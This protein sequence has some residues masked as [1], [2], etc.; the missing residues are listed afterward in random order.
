MPP[1]RI[2]HK[3]NINHQQHERYQLSIPKPIAAPV[4]TQKPVAAPQKV[5]NMNNYLQHQ[6][7]VPIFNDRD[8]DSDQNLQEY[9][10]HDEIQRQLSNYNHILDNINIFSTLEEI[11]SKT[12]TNALIIQNQDAY[13]RI[14][15]KTTLQQILEEFHDF[16][17]IGLCNSSSKNDFYNAIEN[18]PSVIAKQHVTRDCFLL[19]SQGIQKYL[20]NVDFND[21]KKGEYNRPLFLYKNEITSILWKSFYRVTHLFDKIYCIHL[22]L[23]VNKKTHM[24]KY[25]YLLNSTESEFFYD[26]ILGYNL[27]SMKCLVD[28]NYYTKAALSQNLKKGALGCNITQKNIINDAVHNEY[29]YVLMLEDDVYFSKKYFLVLDVFFHKHKNID[30]LYLGISNN[31]DNFYKFFEKIDTIYDYSIL[32][33]KK[34][35]NQKICIGGFFAVVLS[36]KALKVFQER[37]NPID[38]ISD[39]LLCD[40]MFDIKKDF[41]DTERTKTN[42]QL[43]SLVIHK[44]LFIVDDSKPSLTESND[45]SMIQYLLLNPTISYLAKIK[46][47][48]FKIFHHYPLQIFISNTIQQWYTKLIDIFTG[49]FESYEVSSNISEETD[50]VLYSPFDNLNINNTQ[51]LYVVIH[52]EKTEFKSLCDICINT[53]KKK[54]HPFSIY[55]PQLFSSLW[56]R[57]QAYKT[58]PIRDKTKF[59][60]YMYSYDMKY[61]VDLFNF[62]S[63]YK[64]VDALGKSCSQRTETDRFVYNKDITYNDIAVEKY[65][66]YK[67]VLA[68]ENGLADGYITEKLINPIIAGSIPIYIGPKD[69]FDIINKKRVIYVYDFPSLTSLVEYIKTVDTDPVLYQ[70]IV[71]ENIFTGTLTWDNFEMYL[72]ENLKKSLGFQSRNIFIGKTDSN[73]DVAIDNLEDKMN[74]SDFLLK[75]DVVIT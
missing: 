43:K 23:D 38:N 32:K 36:K 19:T 14:D 57:R 65:S 34:G 55:F 2:A 37:F 1:S 7:K 6:I 48:Q 47:L 17:V 59:C 52:G 31:E 70:S 15:S 22:A 33:P 53:V 68:L 4:V 18:K 67:F 39:I 51:P 58:F 11:N 28:M 25:C 61:R 56:E 72:K 10:S 35:L 20:D 8:L 73:Y 5:I 60:A 49:L 54:N 24:I 74:P 3:R 9:H 69:A 44:D 64:P 12:L 46:K 45:F 29:E 16:D 13:F 63:T 40:I 75:H 71:N 21:L 26:G 30:I 41:S 62:I 50:I 42:H 66:E 27:P